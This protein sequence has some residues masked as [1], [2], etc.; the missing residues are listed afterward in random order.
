MTWLSCQLINGHLVC[1]ESFRFALLP[2][3]QNC[4]LRQAI[5]ARLER[6]TRSWSAAQPQLTTFTNRYKLL[7]GSMLRVLIT[8]RQSVID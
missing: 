4:G 6:I 3:R 8:I 7:Q 5:L 1:Y 2:K